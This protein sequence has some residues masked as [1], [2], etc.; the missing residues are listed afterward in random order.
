METLKG[1]ATSGLISYV[2]WT[3]GRAFTEAF[4]QQQ[5]G[6]HSASFI[7]RGAAS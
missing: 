4:R 3:W 2:Q 5:G 6:D 7:A 1:P